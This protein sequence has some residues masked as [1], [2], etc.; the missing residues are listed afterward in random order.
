MTKKT[1]PA[2]QETRAQLKIAR[3][4]NQ[5]LEQRVASL[6]DLVEILESQRD[7]AIN[8]LNALANADTVMQKAVDH[9]REIRKLVTEAKALATAPEPEEEPGA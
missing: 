8:R 7:D 9:L 1:K 5:T 4:L 2:I 3:R 6:Q